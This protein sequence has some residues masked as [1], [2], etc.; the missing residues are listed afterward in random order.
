MRIGVISDIHGNDVAFEAV[1]ADLRHQS[2]D[3]IVCLGDAIQGGPQPAQVTQRLRSLACPVVM[4]NADSWLLTGQETEHEKLTPDRARMLNEVRAWSLSKLS[5]S[6][7]TFIKAFKP[8]IEIEL[9]KEKKLLCF[10][11]SPASFYDL[12]FPH[13]PE[14]DIERILGPY[15]NCIL[16]GGHTHWQQ[17]RRLGDSFF[18]N[19]GSVGLTYSHQQSGQQ[20]HTDSWAEYAILT[21]IAGTLGVEF[22]KIPFDVQALIE[23]YQTSQRPYADIAITEYSR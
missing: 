19:P 14:S 18:F 22:R 4:G 17:I 2:I 8:T 5:E 6:D 20:F 13:T 9:S 16:T 12:I 3:R 10:H 11:G 15:K 7:R 21:E 23:V 1:L